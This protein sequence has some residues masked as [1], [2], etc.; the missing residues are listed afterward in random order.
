MTT[1]RDG[2]GGFVNQSCPSDS[3]GSESLELKVDEDQTNKSDSEE[4]SE[5]DLR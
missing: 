3:D 5:S 2:G 1:P 4:S